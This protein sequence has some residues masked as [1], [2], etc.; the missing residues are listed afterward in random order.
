MRSLPVLVWSLAACGNDLPSA[1]SCDVP[2]GADAPTVMQV[3]LVG[4]AASFDD[5]RYS[6][7][8]GKVLAVPEGTGRLYIVDPDTLEVTMAGVPGGAGSVDA[9]ATTIF[10]ADRGGRIVSV[11][12]TTLQQ[13]G[14]QT[15]SG[16]PDYV[17]FSPST[18]E[19]WVT[20]PG[21][22]RIEIL[23]AATLGP[24]TS[25]DLPVAPEGLVFDA[26]GRAYTQGGG[27]AIA[28]DVARRLVVGEWNT[29]CGSS[30]G[31]PQVD[32]AYGLVIAGCSSNGGAAVLTDSGDLRSGFEAGGSAAI[33]AYD[34]ARHH[35][36]LRGDPGSTLDIL[37]TC[38]DGGLGVL[39]RVPI[40]N[41]GHGATAD[42]RGHAWVCDATTGGLQRI[43]DPF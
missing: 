6:P 4:Q 25:I 7:Q 35:L 9:S 14:S 38:P 37:V 32:D 13:T 18:N 8:L 10:V 12:A 43:T 11:D 42:D 41:R 2:A 3:P 31:F 19:V 27:D 40:S 15:V 39:A 1:G 30:H 20:L 22:D 36:Y 24:I 17:R 21:G 5:L 29:G 34:G 26:G 33:L 23:D 16:T 28:I